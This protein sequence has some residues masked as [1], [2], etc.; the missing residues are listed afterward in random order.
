MTMTEHNKALGSV[1]RED[2]IQFL[3]GA[4]RNW[5]HVPKLSEDDIGDVVSE[6]LRFVKNRAALTT[7]PT[8][9][10]AEERD[11]LQRFKEYVHERLDAA[12]V[13][14]HPE[15]EHSAAGC[16]IG[17]RLDIVLSAAVANARLREVLKRVMNALAYEN[18]AAVFMSGVKIGLLRR[19][20]D[21][22]LEANS[23]D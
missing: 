10:A 11:A 4:C 20:I 9:G 18:A 6:L 19:E 2:A 22:A 12:G 21:A 15:G 14:T 23:N 13:P 5:S 3:G 17:D 1:T 8:S 16:R 7:Q